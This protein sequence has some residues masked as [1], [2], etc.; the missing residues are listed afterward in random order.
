MPLNHMSGSPPA[1][2][3]AW[4]QCSSGFTVNPYADRFVVMSYS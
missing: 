1:H 4:D 3:A 2:A